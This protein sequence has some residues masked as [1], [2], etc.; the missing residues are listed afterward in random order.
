MWLQFCSGGVTSRQC[1][2]RAAAA[3]G[4]CPPGPLWPCHPGPLP[5]ACWLAP[6]SR[7]RCG[8]RTES[9]L[10]VGKEEGGFPELGVWAQ[11]HAGH[12]VSVVQEASHPAPR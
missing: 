11:P 2:G 12:R 8:A 10:W 5:R 4:S 3:L 6:A 1:W 7:V 9:W